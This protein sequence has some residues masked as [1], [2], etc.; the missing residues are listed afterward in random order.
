MTKKE[1]QQENTEL[2]LAIK[3]LQETIA[4]LEA[5]LNDMQL[6]SAFGHRGLPWRH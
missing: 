4:K 5:R 6:A 1:L 2:K 3:A